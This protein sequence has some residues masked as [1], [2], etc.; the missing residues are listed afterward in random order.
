[1]PLKNWTIW[2]HIALLPTSPLLEWLV[3]YIEHKPAIWNLNFKK[4]SIQMFPVFKWSVFR[5]PLY[6]F[7]RLWIQ[8]G[9]KCR[10]PTFEINFNFLHSSKGSS[11]TKM[12][13]DKRNKING[14]LFRNVR[15][16][17]DNSFQLVDPV[18]LNPAHLEKEKQDSGNGCWRVRTHV[19]WNKD[20]KHFLFFWNANTP[21]REINGEPLKL[22]KMSIL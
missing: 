8:Y 19:S 3:E 22:S 14:K 18:R 10:K 1:M 6:A 20:D 16:K 4:F 13:R 11:D 2:C 5:S 17:F 9:V 15:G 7:N 21:Y 12:A